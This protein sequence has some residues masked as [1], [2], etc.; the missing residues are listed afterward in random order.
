MEVKINGITYTLDKDTKDHIDT[1]LSQNYLS[2]EDK[3]F[4]EMI[5]GIGGYIN[6]F[7]YLYNLLLNNEYPHKLQIYQLL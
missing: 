4:I 3:E 6:E 1:I 2:D 7:M 5:S